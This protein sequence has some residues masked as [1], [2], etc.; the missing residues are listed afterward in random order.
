MALDWSQCAAVESVPGKLLTSRR[1]A[2]L[3]ASTFPASTVQP[4][5]TTVQPSIFD[6]SMLFT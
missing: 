5:L 6:Y 3:S 4:A 2:L 1:G